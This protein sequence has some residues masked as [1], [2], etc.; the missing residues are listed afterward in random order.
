[1][2]LVKLISERTTPAVLAGAGGLT[3]VSPD[4]VL[5]GFGAAVP[6]IL[7]GLIGAFRA[8]GAVDALGAALGRSDELAGLAEADPA[9]A[10][11]TGT[12]LLNTIVGQGTGGTLAGVLA[13]YAGIP[14]AGAGALLGMAATLVLGTLG[15][16]AAGAGLDAAGA[17]ALLERQKDAVARAMPPDFARALDGTV[18]MAGLAERGAR[19]A[20]PED[21]APPSRMV[22]LEPLP[23]TVR[24][25]PNWLLWAPGL[26]LLAVVVWFAMQLFA[27]A[28][29]PVVPTETAAVDPLVA[30]SVNVGTEMQGII[31]EINGALASITD[32]TTAEAALPRLAAARDALVSLEGPVATLP[33]EGHAALRDIITAAMP[34]I[35]DGADN[36]LT[37]AKVVDLAGPVVTD[38]LA[39]LDAF[40]S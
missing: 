38:I 3:G 11:A 7:A 37:D 25:R 39:R 20:A 29:E 6:G 17:L 9:A 26:V 35:E 13:G 22:P 8:P 28:P 15:R 14:R 4:A 12:Q 30:G 16:E 10:A 1:M 32:A 31:A 23:P 18:L 36:V 21:S 5:K 27:P 19:P 2:D 40:S 24:A 33:L 34:G